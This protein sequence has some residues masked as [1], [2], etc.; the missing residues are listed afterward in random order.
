MARG[1]QLEGADAI[2]Q[3]LRELREL[4]KRAPTSALTAALMVGARLIRDRAR[5]NVRVRTGALRRNIVAARGRPRGDESARA[6]V[7]I[8]GGGRAPYARNRRNR[9]LRRVGRFYQAEGTTYYFR[10]LE[11]GTR[12]MRAKPFLTP[13]LAT[14]SERAIEAVAKALEPAVNRAIARAGGFRL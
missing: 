10:F 6:V 8:V 4:S 12:K 5:A 11:L 7:G 13:A 2:L 14:E 1:A 3:R 9:R